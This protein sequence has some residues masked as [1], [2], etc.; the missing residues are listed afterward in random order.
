MIYLSAGHNL[1]SPT[2]KA[3]PGAVR[4]AL[5]EVNLTIIQRDLT[6]AELSK[7]GVKVERDTN[8]E[9]LGQYLARLKK[10]VKPSDIAMEYHFDAAS[11]AATGATSVIGDDA[12]QIS[13]DLAKE[14]VD[15]T[16]RIL[17]IRNRGVITEAQSHR[18]KLGFMRLACP[19][20][21]LELAFISNPSD[22]DKWEDKRDELAKEHAKIL[23]KY[24][25]LK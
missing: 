4:G 11:Q 19:C 17:G 8:T 22:T 14:M 3:D 9:T 6:I 7:L 1:G 21:I 25:A 15:A 13:K 24:D 18:G 23:K 16:A 2:T 20:L 5:H 10:K 12:S